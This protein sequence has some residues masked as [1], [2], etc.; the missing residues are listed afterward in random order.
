MNGT[1]I[2]DTD[3][4]TSQHIDTQCVAVPTCLANSGD[5]RKVVSHIFGRNKSCTRELPQD[6]W[7]F[8]CR[9]HYQR[10]KYRAEDNEKWHLRQMD[11]VHDQLQIFED[12]GQIRSWTIALRK[13]E[14]IALAK[15]K[16]EAKLNKD[17]VT[18]THR[19]PPCWERFLVPHL[20]THK[21]FADVRKVLDVIQHEFDS[22]GYKK[23]DKK[24]KM[25]PGVEF[26]PTV[27]TAKEVKK[28]APTKKSDTGYK[29]ITLD[30]PAFQRKT[31]ANAEYVKEKAAQ[32]A[33]SSNTPKGSR[34][35]SQKVKYPVTDSQASSPAALRRDASTPDIGTIALTNATHKPA[36]KTLTSKRTERNSLTNVAKAALLDD[37]YNS[38]MTK[39]RRLTRGF[40]KHGSDGE[41]TKV[42]PKK[43]QGDTTEDESS[44]TMA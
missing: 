11:L 4:D 6:L 13:A 40:E 44:E 27:S 29:K 19:A 9:K 35:P 26:L 24:L 39:R 25:F 5:H 14:Q 12:W 32:K 31:R 28:P 23:R 3:D 36:D 16:K 30:Q 15:M 43:E 41:D 7:I 21:T 33:K 38:Q 37:Q 18:N 8:W 22:Q 1:R 10:M 42:V 2:T 34:T 17:G 20:G